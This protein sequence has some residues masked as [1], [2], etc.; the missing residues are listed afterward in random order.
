MKHYGLVLKEWLRN[1]EIGDQGYKYLQSR[2]KITVSSSAKNSRD[3][4]MGLDQN[5]DLFISHEAISEDLI[6]ALPKFMNLESN[7]S[8]KPK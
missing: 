4:A 1:N 3:N 7:G 5:L 6:I 2:T 8:R